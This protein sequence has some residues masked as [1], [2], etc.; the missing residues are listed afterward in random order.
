MK[1]CIVLFLALLQQCPFFQGHVVIL[2]EAH[3]V[4]RMCEESASLQ[5]RSTD[6]ALC[7]EEVTQV[8]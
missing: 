7:I 8:C 6:V 1:D 2:D 5:L 4:E 3:N